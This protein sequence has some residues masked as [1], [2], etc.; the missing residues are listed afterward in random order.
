MYSE[1]SRNKRKTA[2]L[3]F[4]F[5]LLIGGLAYLFGAYFQNWAITSGAII[6]SILYA[7]FSYFGSATAAL[8]ITGA[9]EIQK[10]DNPRLWRVV[11]NLAIT[12]GMPMPKVHIV[13]DPALNA[14][15]TGRDPDHAHVAI[16]SGLLD[17]LEDTE[18]EGVMAHEMGHIKNYDIRVSLV[19]FGLVLVVSLLSDLLLRIAF[20]SDSDDRPAFLSL[21]AVVAAIFAPMIAVIVQAAVSRQREFLAD[22]TGAQTTRYP[23][24]LAKALEK[25]QNGNPR[26]R[27]ASSATAHLF[28]ANPL[29]KNMFSRLL[30]THPPTEERIK[31]LHQIGGKV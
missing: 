29:K 19:V 12:T 23:D 9:K 17:I 22:A 14:F 15:A 16:T 21:L 27:R 2:I 26:V 20:W 6:G 10:R 13:D 30:S 8:K 31:R 5:L 11:E 3:I 24:G 7:L 28:F 4:A 18:L 25:I 1:I